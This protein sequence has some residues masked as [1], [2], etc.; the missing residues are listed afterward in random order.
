LGNI[1]GFSEE[2]SG[3][4]AALND[5]NQIKFWKNFSF[6][7]SKPLNFRMNDS[8]KSITFIQRDLLAVGG[9]KI[10]IINLK[11]QLVVSTLVE[12][13]GYVNALQSV[14]IMN[15]TYL[16][17]G[18]DD[19]TI[20]IWD[21]TFNLATTKNHSG[22]VLALAYDSK[23][24][25]IASSSNN[26][27]H[28]WFPSYKITHEKETLQ[29]NILAM[30]VL[31][32]GLIA[33]ASNEIRIWKNI[34]NELKLI[35]YLTEHNGKITA[36]ILLNNKSLVS[37]AEDSIKI[38][39]QTNDTS[40][41]CIRT[42]NKGSQAYSLANYQNIL[43]ISGHFDGNIK[44]WNHKTFDLLDTIKNHTKTVHSIIVLA[45]GG[46]ATGSLDQTI[47]IWK[48]MNNASF[49]VLKEL[50]DHKNLVN[51]LALLPNNKF[52]SSSTDGKII[53]WDQ[54][55]LETLHILE[56]NNIK[57][58]GLA[59]LNNQ[60]FISYSGDKKAIIWDSYFFEKI[61]DIIMPESF[62]FASSYSENKFISV[63]F[64][65]LIQIWDTKKF[66]INEIAKTTTNDV[67]SLA[68]FHDKYLLSGHA[69]GKI[70]IW[71]IDID[72]KGNPIKLNNIHILQRH[73]ADITCLIT[74][75]NQSFA[76][77]SDDK[78]V[79]IWDSNFKNISTLN[80]HNGKINTMIFVNSTYLVTASNDTFLRIFKTRDIH[81]INSFKPHLESVQDFA[82]L[83]DKSELFATCSVD[84]L[85][86][87][88]KNSTLI[89]TLI[90]H[91]DYVYTLQYSATNKILISGSR[92]KSIKLWDISNNTLVYSLY[93]HNN[94]VISLALIPNLTQTTILASGS[95][96]CKIMI[97]DIISFKLMHTLI[98][99]TGCVNALT[100]FRSKYLVSASSDKN[101]FFWDIDNG[102]KYIGKL[103][104]PNKVITSLVVW[105]NKIAFASKD[106]SISIWSPYSFKKTNE[107]EKTHDKE[108]K[109]ICVLSNGFIATSSEDTFI[110]IWN[111]TKN[112]N[113]FLLIANLTGH[114]H[115]INVLIL[116]NNKSLASGSDDGTIKIWN[117][118][119]N[120]S[121]ECINTLNQNNKIY[122]LAI[123]Q[124]GFLIS[125]DYSGKIYIWNQKTFENFKILD[126]DPD[127]YPGTVHSIIVFSETY[128]TAA[129]RIIKIWKDFNYSTFLAGHTSI[130]NSLAVL[131]NNR[132][133][134]ASDDKSIRVWNQNNLECILILSEH[135]AFIKQLAVLNFGFVSISANKAIVWDISSFEITRELTL[136]K[137]FN[138][139]TAYLN[140]SFITGGS[141]GTIQVWSQV[142]SQECASITLYGHNDSV[143]DLAFLKNGCLASASFDGTIALWT[144]SIVQ[145][146]NATIWNPHKSDSNKDYNKAVLALKVFPN[147]SLLS[148]SLDGTIKIWNTDLF[149]LNSTLY[150]YN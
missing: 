91:N 62:K 81:V 74:V 38:W 23:R 7:N 17:S 36:L 22:S 118:N 30:C 140:D 77:S 15:K 144:S 59:V 25:M 14:K 24:K 39:N 47:K 94:S 53:I 130:V 145:L 123:D 89:A 55:T 60:Y 122:S 57:V 121:F 18:S 147:G 110:L 68:F 11:N 44:I 54:N 46:L 72:K 116:L 21:D 134:S 4:L 70:N 80:Q 115:R 119:E 19:F 106:N 111:I 71:E 99:H 90:G 112:E 16:L 98:G 37:S 105:A 87:I 64:R 52:A 135:N 101:I 84:N 127:L 113:S 9:K 78:K 93:G 86:K 120:F 26:L 124:K 109:A 33:T 149:L 129:N 28:V 6:D 34:E 32:K 42:L 141:N 126:G 114:I 10:E 143:T 139:V 132:F 66:D 79:I 49:E 131:P 45:N 146:N 50:K 51:T 29:K 88:W 97:W 2:D 65:S 83:D 43:L 95:C 67:M 142:W 104:C 8:V 58:L 63:D 75:N 48:S 103:A 125:G 61:T 41:E 100:V 1:I 76:S 133:A 137:T 5:K 40:F 108:I 56:D 148:S 92:D 128:A 96:D 27:I 3:G 31:S 117:Q 107:I 150:K 85:I 138:T 102:F 69:K 35:A 73:L 136:Q 82:F 12:H 20:R 13:S